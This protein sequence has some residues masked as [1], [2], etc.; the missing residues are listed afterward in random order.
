[1]GVKWVVLWF[2][3]RVAVNSIE[4]RIHLVSPAGGEELKRGD[5]GETCGKY[6]KNGKQGF[7]LRTFESF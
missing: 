5:F 2:G 4:S 1:M 3:C 7:M 6:I